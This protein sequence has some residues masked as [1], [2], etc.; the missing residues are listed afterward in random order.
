MKGMILAAGEGTRLH[1][2]TQNLP[3]PMVRVSGKPI[4]EHNIRLLSHY[5]ICE[6]VVNLHHSPE[7][8]TSYFGSGESFG[9]SITYSY[10]PSLLGTA[11]AVKKMES[12]FDEHFLVVYGD[13]LTNCSIEQF[14]AFHREKKGIGSIALFYRENPESSGIASLDEN[15]KILHFIEKPRTQ[16]IFSRWVNA[17]FLILEPEILK[18]I[19]SD[20][21]SDFGKE[22]FPELIKNGHTLYGYKM[23][24]QLW[25]IDTLEDYQ[26][27]QELSLKGSLTLL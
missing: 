16:E 14:Q 26:K 3:K 7:A 18:Y 2:L 24:E 9:V 5:G 17:G 6:V 22:I 15:D 8:I 12:F 27:L 4:L 10:E 25:W 21:A 13:N 11:G 23:K 20:R 19:P 1:P